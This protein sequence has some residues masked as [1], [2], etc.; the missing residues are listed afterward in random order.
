MVLVVF[1]A[2]VFVENEFDE[3]GYVVGLFEWGGGVNAN[4][5]ENDLVY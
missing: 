5:V 3:G 1:D 4:C 2:V